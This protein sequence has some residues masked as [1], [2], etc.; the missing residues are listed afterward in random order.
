M[1]SEFLAILRCPR[2]GSH[3]SVDNEARSQGGEK[4]SAEVLPGSEPDP[5]LLCRGCGTCV[6]VR[7]GIPRFIDA[8]GARLVAS[9]EQTCKSFSLEWSLHRPGDG[10]W[11]MDLEE[12]VEWFFLGGVGLKKEDVENLKVLDAGCGNGSSTLGVAR[13]GAFC[14]GIDQSTGIDRAGEYFTEVDSKLKAFYVQGNLLEVPFEPRSFDV[15][16]S[17]GVLHHLPDTKRG[18]MALAPLVKPGGRFYVWLYRH[19]KFVTPLVNAIRKV[20]TR[21]EPRVFFVIAVALSP[22][23]QL[24]TYVLRKFRIRDYRPL[25]W[26]ASALALMDIFG[27]PHANAHSFEE[28]CQWFKEAGF[29]SPRL[30]S[31]ERRGFSACG[32]KMQESA[33]GDGHVFQ[34]VGR[35]PKAP[36]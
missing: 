32:T 17:A 36:A 6:P 15:V 29:E 33:A 14:V 8:N 4:T 1:R 3:F 11:S 25:T 18:F 23:F 7:R 30:C 9:D 21:L 19:E 10:T 35:R 16:F 20:T 13:L 22:V 31:L 2:C 26:R 28:V 24:F 5:P 34:T 27:A 12:R